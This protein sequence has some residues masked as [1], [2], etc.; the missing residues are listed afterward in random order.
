MYQ[1]RK[2]LEMLLN[3]ESD[4]KSENVENVVQQTW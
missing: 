4:I 2:I 3:F 1:Y